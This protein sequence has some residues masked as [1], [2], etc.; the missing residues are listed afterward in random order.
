MTAA[1]FRTATLPEL[2]RILD[3]AA[4]EGWNPGI[5]D[6]EA[7]F[8]ADPGGFFVADHDGTPVAAIS[9]VNHSDSFAF[10]GL[11]ICHPDWRGTG[12]GF[13]LWTHAIAHAGGRT[14]GLDGVPAQ[15]DNYA[16]SGFE[17]AGR[18]R[19]LSGSLSREPR[20]LALAQERD[21]ETV[22]ALDRA[23]NG[24]DRAAF[25]AAWVAEH[26][27]R[28]TVLLETAGR[29]TG[30][31]TARLCRE[32]C[33]IGPIV[34]PSDTDAMTLAGQ[35]SAA[36]GQTDISIDVPMGQPDFA[37]M[38]EARGFQEGFA[39]ARMYRGPAP[40]VDATLKAI[41]TMELG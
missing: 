30:F 12:L 4:D 36:L 18:T 27:T 11:Y 8:A 21:L 17:L 29:V 38:L 22:R 10:L 3:W 35:A 31:A 34:A 6:A 20:R 23:A 41:A 13:A 32:V 5:E 19:R 2:S 16:R 24:F 37:R 1:S 39:T 40:A 33:K 15:Q 9:V 14:I 28:K 7:F 26:P 25:L